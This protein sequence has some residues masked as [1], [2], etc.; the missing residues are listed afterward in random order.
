M[1]V[2]EA[3]LISVVIPAY[4]YA[5]TLPRAAESVLSQLDER[6]ELIIIDDGS[7]DDTP[8]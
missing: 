3:V 1:T 2:S 7:T 6:S 5:K 8:L 4:N